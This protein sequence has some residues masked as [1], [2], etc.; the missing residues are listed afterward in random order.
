MST[1]TDP[2]AQKYTHRTLV[3]A[4]EAAT[5]SPKRRRAL[6][7]TGRLPVSVPADTPAIAEVS[8]A[9]EVPSA[10]E[11]LPGTPSNLGLR[12]F[13]DPLPQPSHLRTDELPEGD[14]LRVP[15]RVIRARLHAD[16]P[17]TELWG[18]AGSIPGPTIEART[19]RAARIDWVNELN[20][21]NGERAHLPFDVVRLPAT[22]DQDGNSIP[23]IPQA[24]TPG[25]NLDPLHHDSNGPV[26]QHNPAPNSYPPLEGAAD[27]QAATVVHLHGA[28][29]DGY[30]DGWAH[31][32]VLPG[33]VARSTYP[34]GQASSTLWY[35]DHAMAVT[36]FN[37][38]SGLAGFYLI[39]DEVEESLCLPTGPH[40]LV[41]M[42]ADRNVE[43]E[44]GEISSFAPTGRLLYKQAGVGDGTA[45]A[46]EVPVTGPFTIVNG[47]IWPTHRAPARWHRLRL[48]NAS[49]A[50]VFRLALYDTTDETIPLATELPSNPEGNFGKDP[51]SFGIR[52]LDDALVVIGTDVGLLPTP[53]RATGGALELGPGE[54]ADLLVDLG[55]LRGRTV[56]LRNESAT[57]INA[58][59]GAVE[60]T[61]MQIEV[62]SERTPDPFTLPEVLNPDYT[63]W[64]RRDDGAVVVGP[65]PERDVVHEY[66]QA[67]LVVIPPGIGD[68][69]HPQLWEMEDVSDTPEDQ[70]GDEEIIRIS[71]PGGNKPMVLRAASKLFDD[72]VHIMIPEG[73]W[74]LWNVLH[75]GGPE[76]PMHIHM[77][78]FQML[79][80]SSWELDTDTGAVVG[81]DPA[82]S[83]TPEPL[84]VPR[85]GPEIDPVTASTKDT[86]VVG[87]GEVVSFLGRFDGASGEFMYHCH[88]L[89]HEDHT[90]MRPF[91]VLPADVLALHGEH[92][93][94]GHGGH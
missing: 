39:R 51:E 37:V 82:T 91:V 27:V 89:D 79:Q 21:C 4:E 44:P 63:R 23:D 53:Q 70:L 72:T 52:R 45:A 54:R 77:A 71:V 61:V 14:A 69:G 56:E 80:R 42:I 92:G 55:A 13:R 47:K 90:M 7:E 94:G 58:K 9:A 6:A 33:H 31:N 38:H 62:D 43:T 29:T 86:W 78:S 10:A 60:A 67:W 41:A 46:T 64:T 93:G 87:P 49:N 68:N 74:A 50:R 8:P 3:T 5:L 57:S 26:P 19:G 20:D 88:I 36:R 30:N 83:S 35:H 40:E 28:L 18:Y 11:H 15:A 22:V 59:P 16:L 75:L 48:V 66:T 25:G 2:S 84:P 73:G 34:N 85:P 65:D 1:T 76:H 81:F 12:K 24:N 32:V 17:E